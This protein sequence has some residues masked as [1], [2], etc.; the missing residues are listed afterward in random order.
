ME[1]DGVLDAVRGTDPEALMVTT[2]E[3]GNSKSSTARLPKP[4]DH[5]MGIAPARARTKYSGYNAQA[6]GLIHEV[7]IMDKCQIAVGVSVDVAKILF[8]IATFI[9][10]L[11][12]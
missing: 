7:T 8:V 5:R 12:L 9:L 4:F 2:A 1:T 11:L 10:A 6:P 3:K